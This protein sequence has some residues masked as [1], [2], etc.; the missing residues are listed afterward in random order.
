MQERKYY[1]QHARYDGKVRQQ[2]GR[3]GGRE[4]ATIHGGEK[5]SRFVTLQHDAGVSTSKFFA[6]ISRTSNVKLQRL[7]QFHRCKCILFVHTLFHISY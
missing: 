5:E 1:G 2:P 7:L 3:A 6:N 4:D